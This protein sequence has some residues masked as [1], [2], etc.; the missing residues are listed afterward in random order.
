MDTQQLHRLKLISQTFINNPEQS[1]K[2]SFHNNFS[3][4]LSHYL[5]LRGES[6]RNLEFPDPQYMEFSEVGTEGTYPAKVCLLNQGKT[7]SLNT[8]RDWFKLKLINFARPR[9]YQVK[10]AKRKGKM[11]DTD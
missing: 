9:N 7:N 11:P 1:F 4:L 3:F 5:L 2:Y 6:L 10:K 8:N